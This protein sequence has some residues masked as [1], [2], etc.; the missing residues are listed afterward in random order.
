MTSVSQDLG[1]TPPPKDGA[2]HSSVSP[3][4]HWGIGMD[5]GRGQREECHLLAT[6]RH[7]LHG[8]LDGGWRVI[9]YAFI[10]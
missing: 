5:E 1:F 3:S 7:H 4:L 8:E 9:G 6:T 2:F 10:V